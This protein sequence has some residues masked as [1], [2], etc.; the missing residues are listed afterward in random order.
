MNEKIRFLQK[1][2]QQLQAFSR[3]FLIHFFGI[4]PAAKRYV[5]AIKLAHIQEG[6]RSL[7][8]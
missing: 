7:I 8:K 4:R 5:Q 1:K 2:K 3:M 6:F